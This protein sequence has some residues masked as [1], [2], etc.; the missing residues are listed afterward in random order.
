MRNQDLFLCSELPLFIPVFPVDSTILARF[1]IV[2]W[3]SLFALPDVLIVLQD[4]LLENLSDLGHLVKFLDVNDVSKIDLN[5]SSSNALDNL[6]TLSEMVTDIHLVSMFTEPVCF[7]LTQFAVC[8]YE[9]RCV[10]IFLELSPFDQLPVVQLLKNCPTLWD[11]RIYK[12]PPLGPVLSQMNLFHTTQLCLSRSSSVLTPHCCLE[13]LLVSLVLAFISKP[14]ILSQSPSCVLHVLPISS[15]TASFQ[16]HLVKSTSYEALHQVIV[17]NLLFHPA[18][19]Q[20]L[21]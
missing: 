4:K 2:R 20:Q 11:P 3:R 18:S 15:L 17:S 1:R 7:I 19:V 10:N 5:L 13:L 21:S 8:M 14:H 12:S 16:L 9:P 6:A